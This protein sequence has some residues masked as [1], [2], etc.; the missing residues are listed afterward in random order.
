MRGL[1]FPLVAVMA[2]AGCAGGDGYERQE[3]DISPYG[4][5]SPYGGGSDARY[6]H[7][8]PSDRAGNPA[9]GGLPPYSNCQYTT[10]C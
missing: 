10:R 5:S 9:Q 1:V 6:Q 2:L 8:G 3:N 7:Y 4:V